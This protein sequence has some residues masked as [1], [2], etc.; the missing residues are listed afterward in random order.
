MALKT[1]LPSPKRIFWIFAL[2][3][4]ISAT[5]LA[6]VN[7]QASSDITDVTTLSSANQGGCL[8][9][10]MI[11][12]QLD[13]SINEKISNDEDAPTRFEEMKEAANSFAT[14]VGT[15]NQN[16][17]NNKTRIGL[18]TFLRNPVVGVGL[19]EDTD[20]FETTVNGLAYQRE[21]GIALGTAIERAQ[22]ALTGNGGRANAKNV[23]IILG[24]GRDPADSNPVAK[25]KQAKDAG[26]TIYAIG[27]GEKGALPDVVSN[28]GFHFD[29]SG[30]QVGTLLSKVSNTECPSTNVQVA[31][32]LDMAIAVDVSGSM[33][34]VIGN[35][36]L[37]ESTTKIRQAKKAIKRLSNQIEAKEETYDQAIK[38]QIGLVTFGKNAQVHL[39][40]TQSQEMVR[41]YVSKIRRRDDTSIGDAIAQSRQMLMSSGNARS[42]ARKVLIIISD[43]QETEQSDSKVINQAISAKNDGI[44]IF[45]IAIS[46]AGLLNRIAS[47]DPPKHAHHDPTAKKIRA[48]TDAITI[49]ACPV[50]LTVRTQISRPILRKTNTATVTYTLTNNS[51][52]SAHNVVLKQALPADL[53]T[54]DNKSSFETT[55]SLLP[56][57]STRTA[58]FKVKVKEGSL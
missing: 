12:L 27:V 54:I 35:P 31:C 1:S 10:V 49:D 5:A 9:D 53:L 19:T 45:T 30:K 14:T 20:K 39:G 4:F 38:T 21:G 29:P 32:K 15:R 55:I 52:T 40:L 36:I 8:A 17:G 16:A 6:M 51:T 58:T 22:A 33:F 43:G 11:L 34:D 47:N 28:N 7:P 24:D 42:D 2:L 57:Q 23:M 25:A 3:A 44:E 48:I 46:E 56:K 18:V 37:G 41:E 26:T 50:N 13:G